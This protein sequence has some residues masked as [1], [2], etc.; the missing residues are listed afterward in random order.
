M[1]INYLWIF[2]GLVVE[3]AFVFGFAG[4]GFLGAMDAVGGVETWAE[5]FLLALAA[6]SSA[7]LDQ[8]GQI[9]GKFFLFL[10][11]HLASRFIG[12]LLL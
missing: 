7:G 3:V 12:G 4:V 11:F 10:V 5:Q 6:A 2:T 8:I 9:D 1:A